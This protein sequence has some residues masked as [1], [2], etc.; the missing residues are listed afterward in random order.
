M[1]DTT[2]VYDKAKYHFE[3]IEHLGLPEEH[4]YNHTTF[5]M[6]W[7][8]RKRLMSDWFEQECQPEVARYRAG[9]MSI[10]QLYE[11]WDCCLVSDML[12]DE[13]NSFAEHYFEFEK[14]GYLAD[15][16]EHLQRDL[17]SEFHVSYTPENEVIAHGFISDRYSAWKRPQS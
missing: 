8:V 15:Y 7:L 4:C 5:F 6:S 9:T 17:P 13:G 1:S 10:N 16:S 3:T 2:F 14:G 11:H 12:S